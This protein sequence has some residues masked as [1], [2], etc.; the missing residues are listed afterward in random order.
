MW[1]VLYRWVTYG[2][3]KLGKP[4]KRPDMQLNTP[5]TVHCGKLSLKRDRLLEGHDESILTAMQ[6]ETSL[7]R[8]HHLKAM[9]SREVSIWCP[10]LIGRCFNICVTD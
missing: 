5:G 3:Y 7:L 6:T 4:L 8:N 10:S 2:Q 1:L 9:N